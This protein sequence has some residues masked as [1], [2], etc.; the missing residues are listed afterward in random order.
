VAVFGTPELQ[1]RF[2]AVHP[3]ARGG[4]GAPGLAATAAAWSQCQDWLDEVVRYLE[5]NRDLVAGHVADH[6]PDVKHH[7]PEATYLA[8]L[9]FRAMALE[10]S[11]QRFLFDRARVWLSPG[12]DFGVEGEGFVRLNFATPRPILLQILARMDEALLRE[13]GT[14]TFGAER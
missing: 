10:P 7:R 13:K 6:W 3:H 5:D 2:N 12:E 14:G 11:P 9:D 8:W 1:R 4:L